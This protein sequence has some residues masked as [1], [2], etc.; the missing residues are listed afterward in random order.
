MDISFIIIIE[1][2]VYV[3]SDMCFISGQKK[4]FKK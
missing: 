2:N 4:R 1:L 3:L